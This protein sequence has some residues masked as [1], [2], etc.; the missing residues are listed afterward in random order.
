[1]LL[2]R[3]LL[4]PVLVLGLVTA[5]GLLA[6]HSP[7]TAYRTGERATVEGT[8]VSIVIRSPHSYLEV[9]A[10]DRSRRMRVWAV[11]WGD[12]QTVRAHV[13]RGTLRPG[14]HVVVTGEPARDD[15][16]WRVR[17]LS[18]VRPNDGWQWHEGVR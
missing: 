10:P 12:S 15:G 16:A 13:T 1:M 14:D 9:E 8:I 18:L 3:H 4:L 5:P 2:K 6:H 11:E 7:A 17:L